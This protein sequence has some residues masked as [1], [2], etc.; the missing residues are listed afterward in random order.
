[1]ETHHRMQRSITSVLAAGVLAI[2]FAACS[3]SGQ[4]G[5][6]QPPVQSYPAPTLVLPSPGATNVSANIRTIEVST[7]TQTVV[8]TLTL[9]GG[10]QTISL[11]SG[12]LAAKQPNPNSF[13]WVIKVPALAAATTYTLS[14]TV[15]YPGGCLGPP[16][17]HGPS[18]IGSFSTQ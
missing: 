13:L 2:S 9:T 11:G 14:W 7:T 8:G 5:C 3:A 12:R 1:M 6:S 16:V 18:S 17:V 10:G 15:T 4:S